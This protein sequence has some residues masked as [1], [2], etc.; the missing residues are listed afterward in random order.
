LTWKFRAAEVLLPGS[1]FC[2][3]TVN[4]PEEVAF[5]VAVSWEEE[6]KVVESAEPLRS[7]CAPET[8]LDPVMV[9][10]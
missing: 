1:E 10:E 2:T 6:T 7:T 8:K 5:P 4:V 9:R 3:A